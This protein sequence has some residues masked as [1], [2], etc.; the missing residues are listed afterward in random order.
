MVLE[1]VGQHLKG[2][3]KDTFITVSS[4]PVLLCCELSV[5]EADQ[6]V[7]SQMYSL[8]PSNPISHQNS[9]Y[10]I[11][12]GNRPPPH[13]ILALSFWLAW[14][15]MI[16]PECHPDCFAKPNL[17]LEAGIAHMQ[18]S[19]PKPPQLSAV[20]LTSLSGIGRSVHVRV[21]G[22]G[23]KTSR[24]RQITRLCSLRLADYSRLVGFRD[25]WERIV[26][27]EQRSVR[28]LNRRADV[29]DFPA[30]PPYTHHKHYPLWPLMISP[31]SLSHFQPE[32]SWHQLPPKSTARKHS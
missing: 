31:S 18:N 3:E 22:W 32:L 13:S 8:P 23:W 16:Q 21:V 10:T 17:S 12:T 28:R 15:C 2:A 27:F 30:P 6:K 1:E 7:S 19:C 14:A 20:K 9:S 29:S 4:T 26:R 24:D 5:D 25:E 11:N